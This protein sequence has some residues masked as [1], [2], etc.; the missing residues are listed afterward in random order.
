[1]LR[2]ISVSNPQVHSGPAQNTVMNRMTR[3]Q[4]EVF[5]WRSWWLFRCTKC[6]NSTKKSSSVRHKQSNWLNNNR[7]LFLSYIWTSYKKHSDISVFKSFN[8]SARK[9]V[10]SVKIKKL[11]LLKT[12]EVS[13]QYH[14]LW[15]AIKVSFSR[16]LT[17]P[18]QNRWAWERWHRSTCSLRRWAQVSL[19]VR[20]ISFLLPRLSLTRLRQHSAV[21]LILH[22]I[23][24]TCS[25]TNHKLFMCEQKE[26]ASEITQAVSLRNKVV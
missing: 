24:F 18:P 23:L 8:Y 7:D 1:M 16:T 21:S 4:L 5:R 13:A 9:Q 12:P 15:L 10:T 3:L 11:E 25:T 14:P 19:P 17:R 22:Q 6:L 2:I 26:N 20:L